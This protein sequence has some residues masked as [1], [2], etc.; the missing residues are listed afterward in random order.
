MKSE[1]GKDPHTE[2]IKL[3]EKSREAKMPKE[4]EEVAIKELE[5]MR[6]INRIAMRSPEPIWLS[7]P[8][9]VEQRRWTAWTSVWR[10]KFSTKTTMAL[11]K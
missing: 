3:E 4:L 2:E 8:H 5:R 10:Q 1:L 9:P 11:K 7:D 6:D